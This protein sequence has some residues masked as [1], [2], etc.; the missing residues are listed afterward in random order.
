MPVQIIQQ[1]DSTDITKEG[2]PIRASLTTDDSTYRITFEIRNDTP[3]TLFDFS[4]DSNYPLVDTILPD[5][6]APHTTAELVMI[7]DGAKLYNMLAV[8]KPPKLRNQIL[9]RHRVQS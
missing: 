3:T 4:I 6:V 8:D 7:V 1:Y 2:T 5:M 9:Y